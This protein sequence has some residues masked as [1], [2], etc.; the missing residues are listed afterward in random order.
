MNG[1][2]SYRC[3][4]AKWQR[5]FLGIRQKLLISN[6][7]VTVE[8]LK[9]GAADEPT[10]RDRF[11]DTIESEIKRLS[12]LIHDLLDLGRLEAGV[13]YLEQQTISLQGLV[14]RAVKAMESRLQAQAVNVKLDVVDLPLQGDAERLLQAG[15]FHC[16]QRKD[17]SP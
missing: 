17:A 14:N 7:S 9:N 6:V 10:L 16:H 1:R 12:R 15:F 3:D 13:S 5:S 2:N 4:Y 11:F 8:A